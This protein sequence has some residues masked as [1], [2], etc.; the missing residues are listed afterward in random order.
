MKT[1][2]TL[3]LLLAMAGAASAQTT[4]WRCGASYSDTACPGGREVV[5]ADARTAG[6]RAAAADVLARDRALADRLR[7][8][9]L[10]LARENAS[11]SGL[12][13]IGAGWQDAAVK[14]KSKKP[15]KPK[16]VKKHPKA[17]PKKPKA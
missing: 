6:D 8:E 3:A 15:A 10:A 17:S 2:T 4:A 5:I 7:D 1:T 14:T 12:A 11:G 13:T 16:A 9:R